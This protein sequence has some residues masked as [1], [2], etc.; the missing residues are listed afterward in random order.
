MAEIDNKTTRVNKWKIAF[1]V[2]AVI[3]EVTREIA[4]IASNS[5]PT[6]NTSGTA[7]ISENGGYVSANGEWVRTNLGPS[8]VR[9]PAT[10]ECRKNLGICIETTVH[11]LDNT[12]MA[13][14]VSI[15]EARF[16]DEGITWTND[17]PACATYKVRIDFK[18]DKVFSER[19]KKVPI[20]ANGLMGQ[21][22][23][24]LENLI[25]ME[26]KKSSQD[27]VDLTKDHFLP[28]FSL[29]RFLFGK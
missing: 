12:V 16:A 10:I 1:F 7:Y 9:T 15:Y 11:V 5:T 17:N 21:D 19:R 26:L 4:V 8:L 20:D 6:I 14:D 23:S 22:C 3:F 18:S 24:H 27:E 2:L 25:V 29:L 13:P 28:V